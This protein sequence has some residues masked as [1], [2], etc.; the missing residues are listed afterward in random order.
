[1][2]HTSRQWHCRDVCK[3]WLWS[4]A[5]ILQQSVLNF[6]RISDS[7]EICLVGRAP[8]VSPSL[9]GSV[10]KERCT[11]WRGRS[12]C[13]SS[14]R[15]PHAGNRKHWCGSW[16]GALRAFLWLVHR[17]SYRYVFWV[18][19][20]QKEQR[21][22]DLLKIRISHQIPCK[23]PLSLYVRNFRQTLKVS[24]WYITLVVSI[25]KASHNTYFALNWC[26]LLET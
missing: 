3:I 12:A 19:Q 23:H 20:R 9:R 10:T 2:L 5:Y 15:N 21:T 13:G 22:L 16:C 7:I 24:P 4:T 6:H 11:L 25:C 1:M 8:G 26:F 18:R 14:L 17:T